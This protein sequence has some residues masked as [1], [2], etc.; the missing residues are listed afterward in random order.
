MCNLQKA[1]CQLKNNKCRD[2]HGHINELY[3]HLG[4][5]GLE[6]LLILLNRI[7]EE[8]IMPGKLQL[9]NITTVYKGKD[10]EK[11]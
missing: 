9:S 1:I 5:T 11:T 6:G 4:Q 8:L 2:P 7:K 10:R 3:K